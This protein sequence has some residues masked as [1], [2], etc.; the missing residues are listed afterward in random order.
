MTWIQP[1][2]GGIPPKGLRGHSANLLNSNLYIFGGYDGTGRSN[3]LY[4]FN[5]DN[6]KWLNMPQI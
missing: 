3:D 5:I 4:I 2:I 6:Y 1:I